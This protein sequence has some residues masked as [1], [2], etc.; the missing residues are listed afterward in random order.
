MPT[1][2]ITPPEGD[3]PG[4]PT[5]R[6]ESSAAGRVFGL[7]AVLAV[8]GLAITTLLTLSNPDGTVPEPQQFPTVLDAPSATSVAP[9]IDPSPTESASKSPSES[10]S[11]S[12]SDSG[13]PSPSESESPSPTATPTQTVEPTPSPTITPTTT[14]TPTP[15]PTIPT[16][17]NEESAQLALPGSS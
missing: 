13:S 14:P 15:P 2:P 17:P 5:G 8:V 9:T 11:P 3:E 10:P 16:L 4:E 7:I 1:E 12:D 6:S